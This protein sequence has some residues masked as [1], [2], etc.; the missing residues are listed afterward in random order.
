[1]TELVHELRQALRMLWKHPGFTVVAVL[2]LALGIAANTAIFSV[3]NAVLLAPLPFA[4]PERLAFLWVQREEGTREPVSAPD[5]LAW[6]EGSRDA[7]EALAAVASVPFNLAGEGTPERL[8]GASVSTNFFDVL[9]VEAALGTT[10]RSDPAGQSPWQVVVL[11]HELWQRRFGGDTR[12]IGRSVRLNDRS[13]EVIG[14]MPER[15]MWP[16]ITPVQALTQDRAELWVPAVKHDV[17]LFGPDVEQDFSQERNLHFLR[18]VGRLKEGVALEAA[19]RA[20][21]LVAERRAREFPD[22]NAKAG[23]QAVPLREQLVGNV[24]DILWVLLGAVGLVLA[25]ACANVANLFLARA[26]A[27]Q[28]ELAVRV[29]LGAS[30]GRVMR[31]LLLE[32]L[33]LALAAGCVGLLG[34]VWGVDVLLGM[35]T[36]ELPRITEVG[37]DG[38]VL[39][40]T[41]FVSVLTG[42]LFGLVPALQSSAPDLHFALKDAGGRAS[43]G[44]GRSRGALVVGEVALAVVLLIGAGL[45]LRS[46]WRLQAVEP[47]FQTDHALTWSLSLPPG[48]YPDERRQAAFFQDVVAR[49]EALPG[50]KSAAAV[51]TLP[52]DGNDISLALF[53]EGRPAAEPGPQRTLGLQMVTPGY[54]RTLGIPL[55]QGRD[56]ASTD[57]ADTGPVVL[58]N[59]AA[60][61][62]FWPGQDPL[63]QRVRIGSPEDGW[64]TVVGVVDDV[65]H[66]GPTAE[67][68]AELYVPIMQSTFPSMQFVARTEGEPL[69]LAAAVRSAVAE[70]DA[71][72]PVSQVRTLDAVVASATA[73]PR[74]LSALVG[75]FAALALLLAGVGL[76]GVIAYMARQRTQEI[77]IRMA[78]GARPE[79]VLRLV[80]GRGMRLAVLG[81]GLGL[82]AAWA[83]TRVLG[84]MLHGVSAT[85]PLTFGSLAL[86][87]LGVTMVATWLPARRATRVDPLVALRSE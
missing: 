29:A 13:Y 68:R 17:P 52:F 18:V 24:R 36:S 47:G 15:F 60:V 11:S 30:R 63:G 66:G 82:L 19:A 40:F 50:V 55:R 54:F 86:L 51:V 58:V 25:I 62:K 83:A 16:S 57:T 7:F 72:L 42:V 69:A 3:V 85:D 56:F 38:R 33:V 2:T 75:V 65:R 48:D 37:L 28:R 77:G 87:V 45:L 1:M 64:R 43:P 20:V 79:D 74:F 4:E 34:A 41:L 23:V 70:L 8:R 21:G 49:V 71:D 32:S 73:R 46:L 59:A 9:G 35:S 31:L 78:L 84:S 61:R 6:R 12:L 22:T 5:F 26:T 14:V 39:A 44:G 81:V 53:I 10:F 80:L 27:R 67:P 76:Y